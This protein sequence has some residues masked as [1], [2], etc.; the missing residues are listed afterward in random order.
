[1]SLTLEG[2]PPFRELESTAHASEPTPA[3]DPVEPSDFERLLHGVGSAIDRGEA[4]MDR[5]ASG[6]YASLDA[7]TLIALQAGIYR[8]SEA[9]DLTSKLVDRVTTGARTILQA[10]H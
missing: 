7:A 2:L 5:A 10:G 8:Y 4:I 9:I 1:M 6:R 3:R